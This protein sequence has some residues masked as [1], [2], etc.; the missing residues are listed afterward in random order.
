MKD[1]NFRYIRFLYLSFLTFFGSGLAP[2]APGTF[3]SLAT[4][5]LILLIAHLNASFLFV[6]SFTSALTIVACFVAHYA[7]K[8]EGVH[9]PGWIVIDEVIG[10]L[11]TWLFVFPNTNIITLTF[12]F[13]IFRVFDIIKIFPANWADKNIKNGAGT[14]IDDVISGIYAGITLLLLQSFRLIA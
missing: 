13:I 2:K 5:P 7:Q 3:G 1:Q 11:V 9:D 4:I 12:V 8:K 6:L 14:I 10:M